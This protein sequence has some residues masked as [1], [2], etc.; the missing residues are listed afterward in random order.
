MLQAQQPANIQQPDCI[1]CPSA[2]SSTASSVELSFERQGLPIPRFVITVYDDTGLDSYQGEEAAEPARGS[3]IQPSSRPFKRQF[4][5][6][7]GTRSR[8]FSLARD[9]RYFSIACAS[10][11]KNIADTGT[12]MLSYKGSDGS[13]SC[14]YNYTENKQVQALADIFEGIAETM[15]Q[16]RRLDFLHRFDRLG[17]DDAIAFLAQEVAAG[18]ALEVGTIEPSLRSIAT[19]DAVM[20]RVRTKAAALL[21]SIPPDASSQN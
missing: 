17:L 15:D 5:I 12:K 14:T 9:L 13:G 6:S 18:H 11:A 16:G 3:T 2:H 10:K 8:I 20:Q 21:A 7:A 4:S 1:G 19:D